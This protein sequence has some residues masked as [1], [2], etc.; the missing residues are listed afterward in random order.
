VTT[1]LQILVIVA[2]PRILG[3]KHDSGVNPSEVGIERINHVGTE[4]AQIRSRVGGGVAGCATS[5]L[6]VPV[7]KVSATYCKRKCSR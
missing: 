6:D 5:K 7:Q 4:G 2:F 3:D 1:H